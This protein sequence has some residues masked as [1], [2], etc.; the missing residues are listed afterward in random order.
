MHI[1]YS[2]MDTRYTNIIYLATYTVMVLTEELLKINP[3]EWNIG[4]KKR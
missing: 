4:R 2:L 1:E 3:Q